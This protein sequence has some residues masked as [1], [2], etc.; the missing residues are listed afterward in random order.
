MSRYEFLLKILKPKLL[1][2][3]EKNFRDLILHCLIAEFV[4]P[5]YISHALVAFPKLPKINQQRLFGKAMRDIEIWKVKAEIRKRFW[6]ENIDIIQK[7]ILICVF[8]VYFVDSANS[9]GALSYSQLIIRFEKF[10]ASV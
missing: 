7:D 3:E 5:T 6:I 8:I 2:L 10:F 9:Q 1:L 4:S